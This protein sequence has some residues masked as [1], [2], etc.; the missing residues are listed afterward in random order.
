MRGSMIET[1]RGVSSEVCQGQSDEI[2]ESWAFIYV[3][4]AA[5]PLVDRVEIERCGVRTTLV[6]VPEQSAAVQAA[7]DL[8]DS[9]V[10]VIE[11]CG[12]LGP[13]WAARVFEATGGR[14]PVGA[15]SY[16]AESVSLF[17][18]WESRDGQSGK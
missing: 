2:V 8:V 7:I 12:M 18:S 1:N 13:V 5:S 6:G 4:P 17:L 14:V 16:G 3:T 9:G 10:N 15:V 11:L